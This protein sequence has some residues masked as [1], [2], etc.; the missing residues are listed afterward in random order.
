MWDAFVN[1]IAA[2]VGAVV[3]GGG[4]AVAVWIWL[5]LKT[6]LLDY[7]GGKLKGLKAEVHGDWAVFNEPQDLVGARSKESPQPV[8]R[9]LIINRTGAPVFVAAAAFKD[10][11]RAFGLFLRSGVSVASRY[12]STAFASAF[13]IKF[14]PNNR[15]P[16]ALLEPEATLETWIRLKAPPAAEM[17]EDRSCGTVLVRYATEKKTGTAALRV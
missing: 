12:Q 16:Y 14:G 1:A 17:I 5:R 11:R 2:E 8:L 6:N 15:T 10:R 4:F 9:I 13:E 3:T 7:W